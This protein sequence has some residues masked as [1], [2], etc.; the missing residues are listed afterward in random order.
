MTVA[1]LLLLA[2]PAGEPLLFIKGAIVL[3]RYETRIR[4]MRVSH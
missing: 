4:F 3:N 1:A 2:R